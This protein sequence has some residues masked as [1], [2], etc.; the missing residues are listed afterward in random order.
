[1]ADSPPQ[2][3]LLELSVQTSSPEEA[4]APTP[5]TIPVRYMEPKVF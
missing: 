1:M 3:D 2:T 5:L 4:C